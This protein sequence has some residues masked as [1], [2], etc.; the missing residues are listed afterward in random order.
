M[1]AHV[2]SFVGS[3]DRA[4]GSFRLQKS[5]SSAWHRA[6]WSEELLEAAESS[7]SS[8][9]RGAKER[10][11]PTSGGKARGSVA[12]PRKG[13]TR[14]GKAL[15]TAG[16]PSFDE[17]VEKGGSG[18]VRQFRFEGSVTGSV[19]GGFILL[20]SRPTRSRRRSAARGTHRS[21]GPARNARRSHPRQK[22]SGAW[23]EIAE[24][25]LRTVKC[26]ITRVIRWGLGSIGRASGA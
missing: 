13:A 12:G 22:T 4:C 25:G 5:T 17:D 1:R 9:E 21:G 16:S 15:R 20:D 6:P 11:K 14:R 3:P 19:R 26:G 18:R 23:I 7:P 10:W 2:R 8:S 24:A